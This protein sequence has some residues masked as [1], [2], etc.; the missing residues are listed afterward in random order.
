MSLLALETHCVLLT[1]KSKHSPV[2][3]VSHSADDCA[4]APYK[5]LQ[6]S[7]VLL[8]LCLEIVSTSCLAQISTSIISTKPDL[9]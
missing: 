6:L 8:C 4:W 9:A 5:H 1:H 3:W 7:T 2:A